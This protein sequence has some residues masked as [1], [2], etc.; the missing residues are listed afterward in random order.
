MTDALFAAIRREMRTDVD[1]DIH[2]CNAD[3]LAARI[4]AAVL[5]VTSHANDAVVADLAR[6]SALLRWLLAEAR[7]KYADLRELYDCNCM[8]STYMGYCLVHGEGGLFRCDDC[9]IEPCECDDE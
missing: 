6:Q 2:D 3:A 4:Q 7:Y 8:D 1:G 5:A 9:N